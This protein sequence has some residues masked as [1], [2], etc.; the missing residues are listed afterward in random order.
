MSDLGLVNTDAS[1]VL[2][3]LVPTLT[4]D[5]VIVVLSSFLYGVLTLLVATSTYILISQGVTRIGHKLLLLGTILL[6]ASSVVYWAATLGYVVS[7]NRALS[8]AADGLFSSSYSGDGTHIPGV[9]TWY[10]IMSAAF[11]VNIGIGDSIVWWRARVLYPDNR[12][13]RRICCFLFSNTFVLGIISTVSSIR[14]ADKTTSPFL[15]IVYTGNQWGIAAVAFSLATNT[16]STSLIS[17]KAWQHRSFLRAHLGARR[18]TTNVVRMLALLVE[19]GV[20]YCLIWL[21]VLAYHICDTV[22]SPQG[23]FWRAV[24]YLHEAALAP[25]IAIYPMLIVVLVALNKSQLDKGIPGQSIHLNA[26]SGSHTLPTST[27]RTNR[28]STVRFATPSRLESGSVSA[29]SCPVLSTLS[30]GTRVDSE[31]LGTWS[32]ESGFAMGACPARKGSLGSTNSR[33]SDRILEEPKQ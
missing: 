23:P 15:P 5:L 18:S 11:T 19:S 17:Y 3:V 31:E 30:L 8:N 24:S 2:Q 1:A 33:H 32:E 14:V 9:E 21:L 28:Y 26:P 16:F 4:D 25:A 13:I 12:I 7:S 27:A 22:T 29:S 20:V 10:C 6:Y